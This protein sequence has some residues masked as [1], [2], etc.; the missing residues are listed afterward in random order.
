VYEDKN[1]ATQAWLNWRGFNDRQPESEN[2]DDELQ[3]DQIVVGGQVEVGP[4]RLTPV[5]REPGNVGPA[6]ILTCGIHANL[7]PEIVVDNQLAP[8]DSKGYHGGTIGDEIAALIS[9]ELGVRV[10]S[11]G[12]VRLSGIGRQGQRKSSGVHFEVPRLARPGRPG[13]EILPRVLSR[14]ADLNSLVRLPQVSRI[15][16]SAHV[17]LARAARAYATGLWWANEDPN[18]AWLQLVTAVEIASKQRQLSATSYS[19]LLRERW[20]ELWTSVETL[21]SDVQKA[22]AE[23]VAP[24]M[25]ATKTFID[26]LTQYAPAPPDERP[27]FS[28]VDWSKMRGH[29]D[30]IYKYRS[31][32][33]HGGKPFPPPMLEVPRMD[34]NGVHQEA[35][36]GLN[37]GGYGGVWDQAETPMLLATFEHIVR[38]ALLRWWGELLEE[39]EDG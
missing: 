34:E 14:T 11:A 1:V 5:V 35:P 20:G 22:I 10:R 32:L 36:W 4:I 18:Q 31:T 28:M 37:M 26:F 13:S 21:D 3:S 38:G 9:L 27:S 30:R 12:T 7:A 19:E 29:V 6:V 8:S 17:E 39:T 33:L 2:F 24:P 16:S 15:S 25:Q 23:R